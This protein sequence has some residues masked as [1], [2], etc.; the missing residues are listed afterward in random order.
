MKVN[1]TTF[2]NLLFLILLTVIETKAQTTIFNADFSTGTGNNAFTMG[3]WTRGNNANFTTTGVTAPYLYLA[4][5]ANNLNTSAITPKI[6]LTGYEKLTLSLKFNFET[7]LDFDG[8]KIL[9]S[10]DDGA[11]WN[12][13]G[14]ESDQAVNWYNRT[15]VS[16]F[17]SNQRAWSG[18]AENTWFSA[19]I[20]LPSQ[21]FDNK[22]NIR[23]AIQFRS[24]SSTNSFRGVAVDDFKIIGYPVTAKT[25]PSC[26]AFDKLEIWYKPDN[27]SALANNAAI[28]IWPNATAINPDWTNAVGTSTTRPLYKNNATSNVNFNPVVNFDGTKSLFSRQ[29]FYNHDIFIVI[30]PGTPISAAIATQDVLMG[31]DYLEIAGNEDITGLSVNNTSTRYGAGVPNIAAYN[32]GPN[33]KYG[34]AIISNTITYDRPVIFNARL[35]A[36]GT[37]MDLF[38]DGVDLGV[39]LNPALMSEVNVE[40]FKLILNSRF[41]IGRS[42]YFGPSFNGD[43]LEIM[44]FSARKSDTDRKKIETYLGIKYGINPG[45]FPVTAISLPHV[46]GEF[47][48]SDGTALWNN[49]LHSGFTYNVA[50]IGR[51]DCTGLNQKQSKSIDPESQLTIGLSDIYATNALNTNTFANDGDYLIWGSTIDP[52]TTMASPIEINLGSTIVTTVTNAT[53]RTWKIVEKTITDIGN[54][55]ISIPAASLASLP[56]LSGNSD[57]VLIIADDANFTTNIETIFLNAVSTNLEA[58]YN[59]NGT[60]YMKIG[61]AEEIIASRHIKFDGTDDYVRFNDI[62]V[63]NSAFSISAWVNGE[64][65]NSSNNDKTIVSKK[66]STQTSYH[67]LIDNTNKV[68]MRFN[69]GTTTSEI[70]SNT[71]LNSNQWRNVTFTLDGSNVGRLYID[72]VLDVQTN[73]NARTDISNV[74]VIGARYI[75]E[76]ST[77]DFFKGKLDEI[78]IWNSALTASEI[79]FVMNQEIEEGIGNTV[80]GKII[81]ATITKNDISSKTWTSDIFAYFNL[82]NYIGTSLNDASGKK[83]RGNLSNYTRY[84]IEEQTAP[85]PYVSAANATWDSSSAWTNGT[86]MYYPNSSLTINSIP[87]RIDW[88]II[89]TAHNVTSVGNKTLLAVI[90]DNNT[91]EID[92]DS[93]LEVS[94]YLKINGKIDLTGKSQLIQTTDSDLDPSGTGILERDQ[95]GSGNLYNYNY[96]SSP[97]STVVSAVSNNTGF[98][99]ANALKDGTNPATPQSIT[100][101]AG[102]NGSA[103]PM[104]IARYWLFK[105]TNLTSEYANWEQI[106][107]NTVLQ[108]AQAYTMKGSGIATP[109]AIATQN[110]V[111]SGKPNN[112]LINHSGIQIG[113][114]NINLI[115]NPY[116]SA[117]NAN[118]FITDNIGAITGTLYFWEHYPSNNSHVLAGY[119]GGYAARNLVGGTPP[120]SPPTISGLG[121]SLRVPGRYIPVA[122]GFFVKGN[123]TGGQIIYQNSQRGFI[124]EDDADS[125]EMFKTQSNLSNSSNSSDQQTTTDTFAKIRLGYS[126]TTNSH[127]QLLIGFMNENADDSHNLGYDGEIIDIQPDDIYFRCGNYNLVIQGV[128]YFNANASYPLTLKSSQ[129]GLVNIMIDSL[130]NFDLNQPIYIH[131]NSNNSYHD[132]TASNLSIMLPA[133]ETANRFSLRFTNQTLS[134][135]DIEINSTLAFYNADDEKIEIINTK[136]QTIEAVTLFSILGQ[137]INHWEI[138]SSETNIK[139]PVKRV[140]TGIYIVKIKMDGNNYFSHKIIIE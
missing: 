48:A 27:L 37:G 102:F 20:D 108:T 77:V 133:G 71:T 34:R 76:S 61:V 2:K 59:F 140:E 116:P 62:P 123:S 103:N 31:D 9:F 95:Q 109:P 106:N 10:T 22:D 57:Y 41:W 17:G 7:E 114:N 81:P 35:N 70:V 90:V 78:R 24:D 42:E 55:K 82:N 4:G 19:S 56:A 52:L 5:Y 60:K 113:I 122:L 67:F 3:S 75:N 46:P 130:E 28:D 44:M 104:N 110:Y 134:S 53:N 129:A 83:L 45:L 63:V 135:N 25:Y 131:D 38:L 15:S 97:V 84:T 125:N 93:K 136:N 43:I 36:A 32:Q 74:F 98:T 13:L 33:T 51:D 120:V 47:I 112:G 94:H 39:T 66:G 132:I 16:A 138:N 118:A 124:K 11:T 49:T 105:F 50:G 73:M 92:N 29:G 12:T 91:L 96:W 18:N 126:G 6:N 58:V 115:G 87:T 79:R 21:G 40:T 54:V 80:S 137:K 127:R 26:S 101:V 85:L 1:K 89:K 86:E 69:N 88:N 121:S 64:G 139:L 23:F 14:K 111:F 99:I 65:S 8:F 30:N 128:G 100:W 72:G 117:L 107:E 68:V 119:Q